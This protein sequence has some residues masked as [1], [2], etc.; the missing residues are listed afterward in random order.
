MASDGIG[1]GVTAREE[2]F[3]MQSPPLGAPSTLGL[4]R[5]LLTIPLLLAPAD[6]QGTVA[7]Q[8]FG[9]FGAAGGAGVPPP[10]P[11]RLLAATHGF[12]QLL[13]HRVFEL[14]GSGNPTMQVVDVRS[15]ADI[16]DNVAANNPI[17]AIQPWPQSATLP[18]G[19]GGNQFI[20]VRFTGDIDLTTVLDSSVAG[21]ASFGLLGTITVVAVNPALGTVV[22]VPGRAFIGGRTYAG[23]S[24]GGQL[25]LQTWFSAS[26]GQLVAN[27]GIDNDQDGVPDG[28]GFPGTEPATSFAGDV[29]LANPATFVFV[30]DADGD[31]ATHETFPAGR[32][33]RLQVSTAVHSTGGPTL[34]DPAL[35]AA[36]VGPDTIAPEVRFVPFGGPL[37]S[38]GDGDVGVDP[39]TSIRVVFTE[40]LQPLSVGSLPD[41]SFPG[42]SPAIAVRFGPPGYVTDVP[43]TALPASPFDLSLY[44]LTPAFAFPGEGPAGLAC[45]PFNRVDVAVNPGTLQDLVQ[46]TNQLAAATFFETGA[47]PGLVNAPVAPDAIY[48]ATVGA[49]PSLAV[50]DLNGFGASTGDPTFDFSLSEGHSNYPNNPN[51]HFQGTSLLPPL[52]PGSCTVD[53][54]SAGVFTLTLDSNLDAR[55]VRPPLVRSLGDMM[56]GH[57]LDGTFDDAPAPFGCQ[58]GGGNVCALDGLKI[59]S[60]ALGGPNTLEPDGPTGILTPGAENLISWAPHPNPPPMQFPPLCIAPNIGTQ[61]PTSVDSGLAHVNL[62]A[63]GDPFGDPGLGIPP[64]G[65]LTPEQNA[66]F[67]GPTQGE[68]LITNCTPYQVRQQVGH[69]LYAVDRVAGEVVVFSSNRMTVIDRIPLP[70]PTTLAMSPELDFLAVV[71]QTADTVSF[72]DIDPASA[73][74][75][76]VVHELQVGSAPRGIAWEPGNEDI[77]V[78]NEGDDTLS[79]VSAFTFQVRKVVGAGQDGPFEVAITPRQTQFGFLRNVYFAYILGRDGQVSVFESGPNG[80]NGWGYDDVIG[81]A[82]V[83]FASPKTIQADPLDVNSAVWIVHEGPFPSGV[84]GEG[85]L[86][87]LVFDSGLLGQ[88]NLTGADLGHPHFRDMQLRVLVSVGEAELS[89]I[90]LDIAFDDLRNLGGLANEHSV[91]SAGTPVPV[92]GKGLVR[93]LPGSGAWVN[94][95]EPRYAFLSVPNPRGGQGVVDVLRLDVAGTPRIDTNAH[96]VGVQSIPLPGVATLMDYFRQ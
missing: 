61:E 15:L 30:P 51:V 28:L 90:P 62:L 94:T 36:T 74:F 73:T 43:F 77:I 18:N 29:L 91:F 76:T 70:D 20:A 1:S 44:V 35:A 52:A 8:L 27:P 24:V 6:A 85:A 87:K 23:T 53:G 14:D 71:N 2:S 7:T 82:G 89:G 10:G 54:G 47:G 3:E 11:F 19:L 68:I 79:I 49:T 75:H 38:P 58:A 26:G 55:L 56:L 59:V 45:G 88:I 12:G 22:P 92:N 84:P 78:C 67:Q 37:I 4:V 40:P 69:F 39:G 50:I 95:N 46:N 63:P 16:I 57:A 32:E 9:P 17:H 34:A 81:Q 80:V 13:P 21:Q 86:S 64:S 96:Q 72:V 42:L 5:A 25:P 60:T 31:L 48:A 33:I 65:L 41:G 83:V 93:R 66:F